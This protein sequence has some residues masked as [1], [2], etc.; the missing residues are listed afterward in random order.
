LCGERSLDKRANEGWVHSR[1]RLRCKVLAGGEQPGSSLQADVSVSQRIGAAN[2]RYFKVQR[3]LFWYPAT[4]TVLQFLLTEIRLACERTRER[5]WNASKS[6][7]LRRVL[8][9]PLR[10]A[11]TISA[12]PGLSI[13]GSRSGAQLSAQKVTMADAADRKR[14]LQVRL[15]ALALHC[16][17][18]VSN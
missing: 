15:R 18:A 2:H 12:Q 16:K 6:S 9:R 3:L 11:G 7:L 4:S 8:R 17:R 10:L 14:K 13:F 1:N 5:D